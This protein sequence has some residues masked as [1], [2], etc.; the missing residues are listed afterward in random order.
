MGATLA[1][2]VFVKV[3]APTAII[4]AV[5]LGNAVGKAVSDA[6]D[7]IGDAFGK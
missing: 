6:A 7:K 3:V 5:V 4:G 2:W 1:C